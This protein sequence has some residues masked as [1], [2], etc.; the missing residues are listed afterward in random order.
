MG[1]GGQN[2]ALAALPLGQTRYPLYRRL[3]GP[4]GWS[5]WVR[6]ISPPTGIQSPDFPACGKSLYWLSYPSPYINNSRK[7]K[8]FTTLYCINLLYIRP[9][10]VEDFLKCLSGI[11]KHLYCMFSSRWFPGVWITDAGES[12]RRKHTEHGESLKSL[13]TYSWIITYNTIRCLMFIQKRS[14]FTVF[15]KRQ[16]KW[17]QKRKSIWKYTYIIVLSR[18]ANTKGKSIPFVY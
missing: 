5:G 6:K 12:P 7:I 1:V 3:G 2:H 8:S 18:T 4:Q 13:N 17:K 15:C 16:T 10:Y 9:Q 14:S 11:V